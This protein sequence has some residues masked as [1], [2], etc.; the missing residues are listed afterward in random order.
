MSDDPRV[1]ELLEEILES[2]LTPEEACIDSPDLLA[3]V[4]DHLARYQRVE[5]QLE[6]MFPSSSAASSTSGGGRPRRP[7]GAL[8]EIPGYTVLEVLGRGG[9]GVVYKARQLKLNRAVAL[10]MLLYGA[11]A[12]PA[13]LSRFM[14]EAK[15]VAALQH[16]HVVQLYDIG[17][18]DGCPYFT[19]ELM[20][21][22]NLG[23][24]LAGAPQPAREAASLL[25]KLVAA[26]VA[27]HQAG[28]VHR[29]LKPAN[30]LLAS[31]GTPKIADF[32]LA[33]DIEAV[34][35]LTLSGARIGTPSYMSP[36]QAMGRTGRIGP[37]ADIYSLGAILYEMLTG[38]PPFRGESAAETERQLLS[39]DPAPP[40][41]L[42]AR[43][44]RDLETICLKCLQKNPEKRYATA[45]ALGEDLRRY[46][47]GEAISARRSGPAERFV[48]W[49]R[50]RPA[51]ATAIAGTVVVA[52]MLLGGGV[53][54]TL[55]Q[56]ERR[57][58][59]EADLRDVT[60]LQEQARWAAARSTLERA[61]ARLGAGTPA[62]LRNRFDRVRHDL[63]LVIQLD[64]IRLTR[65]T[66]G[67]P[68]MYKVQAADAYSGAF[69]AAGLV[70]PA[71]PPDRVAAR[72]RA[73][74]VQVA[75]VDALEDWIVC[76]DDPKKRG[77][78][79][80]VARRADP[81][82]TGW[83]DRI[84][85]A[86]AWQDRA[87]VNQII[88]EVPV[89]RESL[90][91]L[92]VLAERLKA[93]GGDTLDFVKR[94]QA[95][96]PTDFWANLVAGNSVLFRGPKAGESYENLPK[97]AIGYF[98]AALAIRP[99]AAVG[100]CVVG[101]ALRQ[102]RSLD[103]ALR[104][105]QKALEHDPRYAR[106]YTNIGL[107]Y[108]LEGKPDLAID[109]C[110]KAIPLD[111]NYAWTYFELAN[112]QR[113]KGELEEAG[114]NFRKAFALDPTITTASDGLQ[115]VLIRQGRIRDVWAAWKASL[116]AD[117]QPLDNWIGYGQLSLFLGMPDE[118]AR[119][120]R[121]LLTRFSDSPDASVCER[122]SRACLLMPVT[123]DELQKAAAMAD[124]AAA[125]KTTVDPRAYPYYLFAKGL[126]D[127]RAGR[128]ADA[129]AVMRGGASAASV[130]GPRLVLAM[131]EYRLGDSPAARASLAAGVTRFDWSPAQAD[132]RDA[133]IWHV[134]RREAEAMILPHL[135]EFRAGTYWPADNDERLAL[136]GVCQFEGWNARAARLYTESLDADP[137]LAKKPG[138]DL[139]FNAARLA[140]MAG[141]GRGAGP[142]HSTDADRARWRSAARGW[143][144]AELADGQEQLAE[145][146]I[147]KRTLHERAAKWM[148]SP[149][150]AG[151]R[152][153]AAL[154]ALPP[155]ETEQWAAL[156]RQ[157]QAVLDATTDRH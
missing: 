156:W 17:E 50:R 113:A 47:A 31:D 88:H 48:R 56:S 90:S 32:G 4:R 74:A 52:A 144:A 86:D 147:K 120:R 82:A 37:P 136:T 71:D 61:E 89:E 105:Y 143:I 155:A 29:D 34:Q 30:V 55:Q 152:D 8:P 84:L 35:G 3:D 133:W 38:R 128:W 153:A 92:L 43:V 14:R 131:A 66:R 19:M 117:P 62:D 27:A 141:C 44:P 81:D 100:Y 75:V 65:V 16:A 104:Y 157:V 7:V 116:S 109:Y 39:E 78:L 77:W 107:T 146:S 18:R 139:R 127:Y 9:M 119:V 99:D 95:E 2:G 102:G 150:F 98:R 64:T 73:S 49:A 83:R 85:D 124:R 121:E 1:L 13:E 96:H 63:D 23:Q 122:T 70:E 51:T 140:A 151:V 106:A 41:R 93:S 5:A 130:P 57:H 15:A 59:V 101:D 25:S 115:N 11:Y 54:L 97:E 138:A 137:S 129:A 69:A 68:H 21:G 135:A 110:R 91:L 40:S 103:A 148:S 134:L 149:E 24:K 114:I 126:A 60:R 123:G 142:E 118:Y 12:S 76:A 87:A 53:W 20:A 36:E 28:I 42:N 58:A 45:A 10:K 132:K 154:Q 33:H 67:L 112:A 80:E 125:A 111:P 108:R 145:G 22:G 6:V 72:I 26:I 46:L 79:I 94:V